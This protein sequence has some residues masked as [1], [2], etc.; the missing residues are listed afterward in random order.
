MPE[1]NWKG[2]IHSGS[3][4]VGGESGAERRNVGVEPI[5][6]VVQ[7]CVTAGVPVYVKQAS[8]FK[9]G[10]QGEIPDKY[11]AMKQFPK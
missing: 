3:Y 9:S 5:I 1:Q 10:Q 2:Q 8:A 7:Q 11:W 6:S 4:I